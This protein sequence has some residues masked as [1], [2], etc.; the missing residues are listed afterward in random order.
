[1]RSLF[2]IPNPDSDHWTLPLRSTTKTNF[3]VLEFQVNHSNWS[4]YL[5]NCNLHFQN[6][7]VFSVL[8]KKQKKKLYIHDL[9]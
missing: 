6:F 9:Q 8:F 7:W 5:R 3:F 1:M 2:L 4:S